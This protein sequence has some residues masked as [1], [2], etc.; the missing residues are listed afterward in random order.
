MNQYL[1]LSPKLMDQSVPSQ[2]STQHQGMSSR[3]CQQT[4]TF[5]QSN[6]LRPSYFQ[7]DGYLMQTE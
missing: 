7:G 1:L 3:T 6:Q 2:L 5:S 4:P